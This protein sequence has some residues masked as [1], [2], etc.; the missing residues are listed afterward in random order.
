LTEKSIAKRHF[1][2]NAY[3]A[4]VSFHHPEEADFKLTVIFNDAGE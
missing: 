4:T 3:G 2:K 1:D